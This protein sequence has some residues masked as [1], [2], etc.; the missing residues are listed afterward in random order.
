MHG[1]IHTDMDGTIEKRD[2]PGHSQLYSTRTKHER[3]QEG[4]P[5]QEKQASPGLNGTFGYW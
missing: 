2:M 4:K 1:Y 5:E 3:G